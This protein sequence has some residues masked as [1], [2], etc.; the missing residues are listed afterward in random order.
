MSEIRPAPSVEGIS[1]SSHTGSG[2]PAN[3]TKI[4]QEAHSSSESRHSSSP[5]IGT[6]REQ[7]HGKRIQWDFW[8][9]FFTAIGTFLV[10]I[11]LLIRV[12]YE[13]AISDRFRPI[14]S[15]EDRICHGDSASPGTGDDLRW[16]DALQQCE[17]EAGRW[18]AV[19]EE[20]RGLI[21]ALG[22]VAGGQEGE[23]DRAGLTEGRLR[24]EM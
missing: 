22:V 17:A 7:T 3:A 6:P 2:N 9:M 23:P 24:D 20:Y 12:E 11:V 8:I 10:I 19:A 4:S 14:C 13:K 18:K 1:H 5:S 21:T 16:H 15:S